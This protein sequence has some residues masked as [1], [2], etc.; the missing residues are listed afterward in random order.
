[1]KDTLH[2]SQRSDKYTC[3]KIC[4]ALK[5]I[6]QSRSKKKEQQKKQIALPWEKLFIAL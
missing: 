6:Q 3:T 4:M 2:L 5:G 1:M